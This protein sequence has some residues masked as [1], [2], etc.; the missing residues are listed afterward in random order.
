MARNGDMSV[1][2]TFQS[3]SEELAYNSQLVQSIQL[4]FIRCIPAVELTDLQCIS[5]KLTEED[6]QKVRRRQDC[7]GSHAGAR[8]LLDSLRVKPSWFPAFLQALDCREVKLAELKPQF[9][10]LKE[11]VDK[12]WKEKNCANGTSATTS[13]AASASFGTNLVGRNDAS[14]NLVGFGETTRVI[15]PSS[16]WSRQSSQPVQESGEETSW[17]SEETVPKV[18]QRSAMH[19]GASQARPEDDAEDA[20]DYLFDPRL[21]SQRWFHGNMARGQAQ[22]ILKHQCVQSFL[23][24]FNTERR[25]YCVSVVGHK[26]VLNLKVNE[27]TSTG[28]TR[29]YLDSSPER[30]ATITELVDYFRTLPLATLDGPVCLCNPVLRGAENDDVLLCNGSVNAEGARTGESHA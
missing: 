20:Y 27:E 19:S 13:P 5:D 25:H 26:K 30:F 24:R 6:I 10:Q 18:P 17:T 15:N 11:Q 14:T 12:E 16:H 9:L 23:V 22:D 28:A 8:M 7:E 2:L 29:Y 3:F 4:L 21:M 1:S